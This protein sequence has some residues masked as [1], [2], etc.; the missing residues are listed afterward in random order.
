[1]DIWEANSISS[2][3]TP[4]V[5][6]VNGQVRCD[7]PVECGDGSNRY[8]G[9]CDKDGCDF[10]SFRLG[11]KEF[12]G[13]G[14]VVD[15]TKKIT[16]V[17]Q[18]LTNNNQ[19]SGDLV[20]IRRL[21]VQN[22]RVI[23]NSK[24][25]LPGID[26]YDSI[27]DQF[28]IDKKVLFKD[29]NSFNPLGGMKKMGEAF[30]RGMVLVM[31][32]WDDHFAHM[33]WLDSNYHLTVTRLSPVLPVEHAQPTLVFL[34]TSRHDTPTRLSLIR[35][36]S[37]DRSAQLTALLVVALAPNPEPRLPRPRLLKELSRLAMDNA[38]ELAGRKFFYSTACV[39]L[40]LI[41]LFDSGPTQCVSGSTCQAVAA[42]WYYQCL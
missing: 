27:T 4:H 37:G 34:L 5:C 11:D 13:P 33:L 15:T 22:G 16:V 28:C 12:L 29:Q 36:S 10:S 26:D 38:V 14:K 18:F 9:L 32:L 40:L 30:K 8:N 1:M 24:V 19:S 31:S 3:Y 42:P 41:N 23:Q 7:D 25:N 39:L 17:T 2:A 21:Y 20:E 6:S 35:T